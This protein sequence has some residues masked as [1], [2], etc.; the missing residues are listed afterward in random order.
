M[1]RRFQWHGEWNQGGL[2]TD[3]WAIPKGAPNAENAQKFAAFITMAIP[4][5]RLSK[6][7]PY[8]S[9]NNGSGAVHDSRGTEKLPHRAGDQLA[10]C[11]RS[12]GLVG[13]Q[14]R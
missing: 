1:T 6:L 2:F 14:H 12:N 7:I 4:Q 3:V 13:G 5:A 8:G 11:S 10:R 9:V